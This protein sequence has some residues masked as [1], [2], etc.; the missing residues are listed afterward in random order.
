MLA[1]VGFFADAVRAQRTQ[2]DIAQ[3]HLAAVGKRNADRIAVLAQV[4]I[5]DSKRHAA[6]RQRTHQAFQRTPLEYLHAVPADSDIDRALVLDAL[7]QRGT[8]CF[9]RVFDGGFR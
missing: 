8:L 7:N 6:I 1:N 9:L 4:F 5:S 3:L 2:T